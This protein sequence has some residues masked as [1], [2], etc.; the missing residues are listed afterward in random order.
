MPSHQAVP[1]RA[2]P[3]AALAELVRR[4]GTQAGLLAAVLAVVVAGAV[5]L[6]TCSLLLT[7][8]QEQALDAALR[9]ADPQ[10]VAVEVTFRLD[11]ADP[12]VVDDAGRV[13]ADA[14]APVRPT[15]SVWLTSAVRPLGV[16]SV[17]GA[18]GYVV[19]ADA[20]AAHA[21]LTAGRW[22]GATQDGP[23]E[24]AVPGDVAHALRLGVGDEVVL[25]ERR[26]GRA[27]EPVPGSGDV[28]LVVVGTFT[29]VPHTDGPWDRDLLRGAGA[30]TVAGAAPTYGPFA[31]APSALAAS[32]VAVDR[33]SLVAR[34]DLAGRGPADRADVRRDVGSLTSDLRR[35]LGDPVTGVRVRTG[36]GGVLA[37]AETQERVT[38]SVVVVVALLGGAL[39]AAALALAGRLVG[40]RRDAETRLL[41]ARGAAASQLVA[42]AAAESLVLAVVAAVV[43]VPLALALYRALTRLPLLADAGLTS[44]VGPTR[45]LVLSVALGT[46]ALVAVLVAPA[47]RAPDHRRPSRRSVRGRVGRAAADALLVALAVVGCLQLRGRPFAAGGGADPLLV[48][49]PL[50]C[51]VAG[52]VVALRVVPWVARRAEVRAGRSP[53][54]VLPLAS[55]E[56]ARRG[57]STGAALLLVLATAAATFGTSLGATWATSAQDQADTRVGADLAVGRTAA[58]PVAQAAA[59]TALTG[60]VAVPVTDREVALGPVAGPGPATPV[61]RLAAIDTGH[62]AQLVRGRLPA[63]TTWAGL[64]AGLAPD[65][66]ASGIALPASAEGLDVAVTGV[67]AGGRPVPHLTVAPSVVVETAGGARQSVAGAPV[68]LDG[69]PHPQV[70]PLPSDAALQVVAIDLQ[71]AAGS[72]ADVLAQPTESRPLELTVTLTPP[73]TGAVTAPSGGWSGGVAD[74]SLDALR[75]PGDVAVRRAGTGAAVTGRVGLVATALVDGPAHLV[76]TAFR[77]PADVPVLLGSELAGSIAAVPGDTLSLDLG[78]ATLVARVVGVAPGHAALPRGASIVADHDALARAV[79]AHGPPA[80]VVD[81]WWLAGVDDPRATAAQVDAAGLGDPV[82]RADLAAHLRDD[83]LRVGVQLALGL[84]VVAALVLAVAGTVVQTT[85]A[86]D[87]RA[88]DVARLQGMGVPRRVVV[89]TLLVEHGVVTLLVVAGGAVVGAVT[90]L[91]VGPRLVV[92]ATGEVP[93]PAPVGVWPWPAQALLLAVL[94]VACTAVVAPVAARLARRA[95]V[96][97][98]RMEGGQ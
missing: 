8:G 23:V 82:T 68:P 6:G 14:L 52:S 21:D 57:H 13:L 94:L 67:V 5:L 95:T 70:L 35:T 81:V 27:R 40:V 80:D 69:A 97:H 37:A 43:A 42:R 51:L 77:P 64:T 41:V 45:A 25:G 76:L 90:A 24:V 15:T 34:P 86:L 92:S 55:W 38:R 59:L 72:Q 93:V 32:A 83:P 31:A 30:G 73:G 61:T 26:D 84:L 48:A 22:P 66:P 28:T 17:P 65:A 91:V 87:A 33:A 71:V 29:P 39:A 78:S 36:L 63:G 20:L 16:A 89:A 98:L 96:A 58:S 62:D 88:V 47:V 4:G 85:A 10:D 19:A 1:R 60:A 12:G 9:R 7:T 46:L 49:V 44:D 74:D 54:L 50:L 3:T 53:G 18:H 79:V 56:V 75:A 11:G 2:R